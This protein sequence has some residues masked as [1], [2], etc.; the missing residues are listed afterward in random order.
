MTVRD[1]VS[2]ASHPAKH[3][4]LPHQQGRSVALQGTKPKGAGPTW[5]LA[6][7]SG[8]RTRARPPIQKEEALNLPDRMAAV[9]P[10]P[11]KQNLEDPKHVLQRVQRSTGRSAVLWLFSSQFD[12]FPCRRTRP[13]AHTLPDAANV[14]FATPAAHRGWWDGRW[15]VRGDPCSRHPPRL[16]YTLVRPARRE[17]VDRRTRRGNSS[18][19]ASYLSHLC[20]GQRFFLDLLRRAASPV[21]RQVCFP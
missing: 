3:P 2:R 16:L 21:N 10:P 14:S 20:R 4:G 11:D 17:A 13:H 19:F 1:T 5:P 12:P 6:W 15:G 7:K 18:S 8:E 9:V